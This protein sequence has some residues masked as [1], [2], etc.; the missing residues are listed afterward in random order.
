MP[1]TTYR[2]GN[3]RQ[4]AIRAMLIL[5]EEN[6]HDAISIRGI[7]EHIGVAHRAISNQFGNREGLLDA[8]AAWGYNKMADT[9]KN[10]EHQESFVASYLRFAR[11]NRN[12]YALMMSRPHGSMPDKP[13]LRDAVSRVLSKAMRIFGDPNSS[14]DDR[15]RAVMRAYIILHGGLTLAASGVLDVDSDATLQRE[16]QQ[17]L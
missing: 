6:P 4:D 8:V 1:R 14:F 16:L 11:R 9:L 5:L 13:E 12:L 2:H 3:V 10:C 7:A 15:R 17:M